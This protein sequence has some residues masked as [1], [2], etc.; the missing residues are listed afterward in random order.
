MCYQEGT[1]SNLTLPLN[2]G[3][4]IPYAWDEQTLPEVMCVEV[5]GGSNLKLKLD[6]FGD[7]G[8]VIYE[9]YFYIVAYATFSSPEEVT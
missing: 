4:S 3:Q 2:P 6:K 1:K 8:K 5:K 9:S 7:K